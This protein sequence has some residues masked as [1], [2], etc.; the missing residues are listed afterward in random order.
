MTVVNISVSTETTLRTASLVDFSHITIY[1]GVRY[2]N[3]T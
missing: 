1:G 2:F 3:V